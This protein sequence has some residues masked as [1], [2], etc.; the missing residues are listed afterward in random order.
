MEQL[1]KTY[2][3]C[4][5]PHLTDKKTE[6]KGIGFVHCETLTG[7]RLWG[8]SKSSYFIINQLAIWRKWACSNSCSLSQW[9]H[10]TISSSAALFSSCPRSSQHQGLFQ[11]VSSSHQVAKVLELQRQ[12]Q[13][14]QRIVKGWFPLRLTGLI[15]L[16][17]KELSGVF[18][19]TS[20]KASILWHSAFST[21]S[22][23]HDYWKNHSFDYMDLCQQ[24]DVSAF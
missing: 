13:S 12:H 19:S 5:F 23:V 2:E 4:S 8:P 22:T 24:S 17:S 15:S 10:P 7:W 21:L 3:L 18:F 6:V 11:W 16:Q 9:C 14:F 20:L 1:C